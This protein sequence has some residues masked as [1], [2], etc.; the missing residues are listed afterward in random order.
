[1]A[2]PPAAPSLRE[3]LRSDS[4]PAV[5]AALDDD[6]LAALRPLQS[7]EPPVL[8]AIRGVCSV[9][10]LAALLQGGADANATGPDRV[11]P[12]RLL[13]SAPSSRLWAATG[14]PAAVPPASIGTAAAAAKPPAAQHLCWGPASRWQQQQL[15]LQQQWQQPSDRSLEVTCFGELGLPALQPCLS[16]ARRCAYAVCLLSF[17]A[18]AGPGRAEDRHQAAAAAE[19]SGWPKLACLLRHWGGEEA[20][21]LRVLGRSK[22]CCCLG[23]NVDSSVLVPKPDGL[24]E[25]FARSQQHVCLLSLPDAALARVRALLAPPQDES[26]KAAWAVA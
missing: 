16:E 12:L 26:P 18:G 3:A 17:G 14:P 2:T 22:R 5:R 25:G 1:V 15:R 9:K 11:T 13:A 21:A 20:T 4:A 19:A 23:A 24:C 8:A 6:P 7:Q 10:V